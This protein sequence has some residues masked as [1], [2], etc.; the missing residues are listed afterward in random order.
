[1]VDICLPSDIVSV[2]IRIPYRYK[3]TEQCSGK[4][5]AGV[6]GSADDVIRYLDV[7]VRDGEMSTP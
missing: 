5:A 1:M 6:I 3:I 7:Y 4:E 2:Y